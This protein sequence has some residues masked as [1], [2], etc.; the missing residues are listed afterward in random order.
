MSASEHESDTSS[1]EDEDYIPSDH[2]DSD[3][4][5][6]R[7]LIGEIVDEDSADEEGSGYA[8]F[9]INKINKEVLSIQNSI[10]SM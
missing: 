8:F 7:D 9:F 5:I 4:E 6:S 3:D 10:F 1:A 2:G